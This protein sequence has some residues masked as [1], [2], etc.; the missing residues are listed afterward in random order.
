MRDVKTKR[1]ALVLFD[2][3][4]RVLVD[5]VCRVALFLRFPLA[6][7]PIVGHV[8]PPVIDVIDVATDITHKVIESVIHRM[9]L[10]CL[11]CIAEVP[12]ANEPRRIAVLFKKFGKGD[13]V[14]VQTFAMFRVIR[15]R[16]NHRFDTS[17][18]LIETGATLGRDMGGSS[19]V[20]LS[21]FLT[22]S[23]EAASNGEALPAALKAGLDRMQFYGGA[24]V[25][26]RSMVDALAPALAALAAGGLDDAAAAAAAGADGTAAIRVAGVGRSSYVNEADL[27]GVQDPGAAATAIVLA[28]AC[29]AH[30]RD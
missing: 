18:L 6:L 1:S 17:A 25:G 12:L 27:A 14:F 19:G 16:V 21:I 29:D 7:P 13:L 5:E 30:R 8:I 4:Q 24:K 22:A 2:K 15:M 3:L 9:I 11:L 28:A 20:L 26:D 10:R 23:G